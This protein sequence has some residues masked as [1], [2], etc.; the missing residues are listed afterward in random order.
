MYL[1]QHLIQFS[2]IF[3]SAGV[4]TS[5]TLVSY[6]ITG[7]HVTVSNFLYVLEFVHSR[8][9]FLPVVQE[10]GENKSREDL[11]VRRYWSNCGSCKI[12]SAV[13]VGHFDTVRMYKSGSLSLK[14]SPWHCRLRWLLF[15][16]R[17][18]NVLI[19]CWVF[20]GSLHHKQCTFIWFFFFFSLKF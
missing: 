16:N 6:F 8:R 7:L 5:D 19:G 20:F 10:R 14:F 4:P 1:L 3:S 2:W 17:E 9:W 15:Q 13:W 11:N 18:A 12:A